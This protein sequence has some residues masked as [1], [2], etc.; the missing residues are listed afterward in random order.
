YDNCFWVEGELLDDGLS[1]QIGGIEENEGFFN[2]RSLL[3]D[4]DPIAYQVTRYAPT[5]LDPEV[6]EIDTTPTIQFILTLYC[7]EVSS[8]FDNQVRACPVINQ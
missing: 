6:G 4:E 5:N 7:E 3:L 2:I 8:P 1:M